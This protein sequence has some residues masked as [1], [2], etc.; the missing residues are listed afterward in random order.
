MKLKLKMH[1]SQQKTATKYEKLATYKKL[2]NNMIDFALENIDPLIVTN[3]LIIACV[4]VAVKLDNFLLQMRKIFNERLVQIFTKL[5]KHRL[6]VFTMTVDE[7][8]KLCPFLQP[9]EAN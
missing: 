2:F 4:D 7:I 6:E 3:V 8:Y 9:I 5:L 1:F